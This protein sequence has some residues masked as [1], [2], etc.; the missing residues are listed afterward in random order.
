[1]T[2]ICWDGQTLAGDK[3][4]NFGTGH[5]TTTKVRRIGDLLIGCAGSTAK[6]MEFHA[7]VE[8]G[9]KPEDLPVFQKDAKECVEALVIEPDGTVLC[10]SD[11][12]YPFKVE[13][14]FWAI[15]SGRE[16]AMGAMYCGCT[17]SAAVGVASAL[18]INCG[19]GIDTLTLGA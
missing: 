11:S 2:V 17:A 13:N 5:A 15:G 14:R 1:M 19:N 10:Y 18:D 7:W 8:R 9:R 4:T 6:I 3:R 12:A 16:F